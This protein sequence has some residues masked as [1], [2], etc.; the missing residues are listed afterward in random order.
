MSAEE[1][2]AREK[3]KRKQ[4]EAQL[5]AMKRQNNN[6]SSTEPSFKIAKLDKGLSEESKQAKVKTLMEKF[7]QKSNANINGSSPT[8]DKNKKEK[9]VVASKFRNGLK[10]SH[11]DK[12]A[13][14]SQ[15]EYRSHLQKA[16]NGFSKTVLKSDA[17]Q[18][19][20]GN[21]HR[22]QKDISFINQAPKSKQLS[23]T[24]PPKRASNPYAKLMEEANK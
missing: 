14:T 16:S 3:R 6:N 13:L 10:P 20:N 9:D 15:S 4:L 5:K 22:K 21:A 7:K 23:Q 18:K 19:V 12:S 17:V 11:S 8:V 2:Y 24:V 1:R